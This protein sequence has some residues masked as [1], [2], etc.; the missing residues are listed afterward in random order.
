V[1]DELASQR[2]LA[3]ARSTGAVRARDVAAL[4]IAP[5][6]QLQRLVKR[7]L[8]ERT[9]RG[10]YVLPEFEIT[11]HHSLVEVAIRAPQA[12]VCLLSALQFHELGT[13]LPFQVWLAI[14]GHAHRPDFANP[15]L[16]VFRMSGPAFHTEIETHLIEGVPVRVYSAAKTVVDCFKFRNKVGIDVAIEALQDYV[17]KR[18]YAIGALGE[19][20]QAC[21]VANVMRPYIE[22]LI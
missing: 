20:A 6:P 5:G 17:R 19:P 11:E 15:R 9:D 4:G 16:R 8:L 14:E 10:V 3:L 22:A 18:P 2:I 1:P 21:R 12:V 7:G 13:Q